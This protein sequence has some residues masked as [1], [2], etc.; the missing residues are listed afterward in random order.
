MMYDYIIYLYVYMMYIYIYIYTYV[1]AYITHIHKTTS[2]YQKPANER[3]SFSHWNRWLL[4][5]HVRQ[6]TE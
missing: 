5:F 4:C 1:R 2:I 3:K 6:T